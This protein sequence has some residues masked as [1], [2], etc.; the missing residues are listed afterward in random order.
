MR[1]ENV[2]PLAVADHHLSGIRT[3]FKEHGMEVQGK[4][5]TI[6]NEK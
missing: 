3:K 4:Y 6:W 2:A 1:Y 5:Q